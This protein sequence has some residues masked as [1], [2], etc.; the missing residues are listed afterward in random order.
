MSDDLLDLYSFVSEFTDRSWVEHAACKGMDT[1]LFF[2]ERG[3]VKTLQLAKRICSNCPVQD[4]CYQYGKYEKVGVWG[5]ASTLQRQKDRG[6][7]K[8]HNMNKRVTPN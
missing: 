3:D 6:M 1:N 2:P 7:R 4:K 8:N 5:G